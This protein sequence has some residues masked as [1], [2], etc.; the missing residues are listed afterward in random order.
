MLVT[1][2]ELLAISQLSKLHPFVFHS[3][4]APHLLFSMFFPG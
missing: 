4:E 2:H 3:A 1:L